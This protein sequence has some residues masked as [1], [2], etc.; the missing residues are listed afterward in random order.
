MNALYMMKYQGQ[1]GVGTGTML[2]ANGKVLGADFGGG[3]YSGTYSLNDNHCH[4]NAELHFPM[5]GQLVTGHAMAP[6]TRLPLSAVWPAEIATGV[7]LAISV[8]GQEV[9]VLFEK[10]GDVA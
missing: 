7:P 1:T 8:G 10:L 4:I 5:G 2:V 9:F 3:R 6:N